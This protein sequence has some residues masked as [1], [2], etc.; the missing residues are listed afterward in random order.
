MTN[1][2]HTEALLAML[3]VPDLDPRRVATIAPT[4]PPVPLSS[5]MDAAFALAREL[6]AS[7]TRKST[8]IP[9][10]THLMSVAALVGEHGGSEDEMIAALLHDAVEDCGGAPVLVRIQEAFGDAVA[11]IVDACTDD[12]SG[13]EKAPWGPRKLAY[14]RHLATAPL[15]V[16]RVSCA[17]K[18]HN[19]RAIVADLKGDGPS[20]FA[21]FAGGQSG[22]LWYYRALADLFGARLADS[23]QDPGLERMGLGALP[24]RAG[25]GGAG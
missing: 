24:D 2:S 23:L 9:Y 8:A 22:T 12:A 15:P 19:A 17:D 7:Q 18:L 14:I 3:V 20:A 10:L 21:R 1:A 6:H 4:R 5:R 11:A 13:G 25:H 16:L